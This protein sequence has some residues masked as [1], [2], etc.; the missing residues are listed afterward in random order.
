MTFEPR[1]CLRLF[2]IRKKMNWKHLF[3]FYIFE[4]IFFCNK[5]RGIE[6]HKTNPRLYMNWSI[7]IS[8]ADA[9]NPHHLEIP[10][11]KVETS[12]TGDPAEHTRRTHPQ[13]P[14]RICEAFT[15]MQFTDPTHHKTGYWLV[16]PTELKMT[17]SLSI[18]LPQRRIS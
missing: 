14:S 3:S 17:E 12:T 7:L 6:L 10:G 9:S 4:D 16:V 13:T 15:P 1:S 18:P 5:S 2:I 11:S 8:L